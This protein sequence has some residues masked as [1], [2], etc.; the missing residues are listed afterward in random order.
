MVKLKH[1]VLINCRAVV[2]NPGGFKYGS[3]GNKVMI[4]LQK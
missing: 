1:F 4:K 2:P 3:E